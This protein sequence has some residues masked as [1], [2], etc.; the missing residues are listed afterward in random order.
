MWVLVHWVETNEVT[1]TSSDFVTN[2]KMLVDPKL[3]GLVEFGNH[4]EKRPKHGWD[5]YKAK[6]LVVNIHYFILISI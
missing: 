5:L 3:E 1:V 2:K 4:A 6:V